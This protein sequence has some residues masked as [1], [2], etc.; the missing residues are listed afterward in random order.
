MRL[1]STINIVA[2]G[3]EMPFIH[4]QDLPWYVSTLLEFLL[5]DELFL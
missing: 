1:P 5:T 2:V 3:G 4:W